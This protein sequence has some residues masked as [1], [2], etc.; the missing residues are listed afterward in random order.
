VTAAD[1][2]FEY[3]HSEE[4]RRR[5]NRALRLSLYRCAKCGGR[6]GLEVH[7]QTYERIGAER[8]DDLQVLCRDCHLQ[9]TRDQFAGRLYLKIVRLV[10]SDAPT[11]TTTADLMD[12]AKTFCAKK[13]LPYDTAR[14]GPA[15]DLVQESWRR[16]PR[17]TRQRELPP[18][19]V[20]ITVKDAR[21]LW[22]KL[23]ALDAPPLIK[24][25][26]SAG[27][28][29]SETDYNARM[30]E[31]REQAQQISVGYR[32]RRRPLQDR[33]DEIFRTSGD[34]AEG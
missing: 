26:P 5:R 34:D 12:A 16:R 2:Y 19:V 22:D 32:Q 13:K 3:I 10:I 18:T 8:D 30:Q 25:M 6:Y 29:L 23:Q 17:Q 31:L 27:A 4:W 24:A 1:F 28:P 7:H 11:A 9:T 21:A 15:F 14:L 33:L 20:D